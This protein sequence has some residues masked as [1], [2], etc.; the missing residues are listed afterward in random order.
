MGPPWF[1]LPYP[2]FLPNTN[3]TCPHP[4][5]EGRSAW[6][7]YMFDVMAHI[8]QERGGASGWDVWYQPT[9]LGRGEWAGRW[10]LEVVVVVDEPKI[11]HDRH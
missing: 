2:L 3:E 6:A 1:F 11:N 10:H 7:G 8:P 9:S 4:S 5:K